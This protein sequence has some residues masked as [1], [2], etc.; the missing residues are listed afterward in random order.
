MS[1]F[2]NPQTGIS[3]LPHG[4]LTGLGQVAPLFKGEDEVAWLWLMVLGRKEEGVAQCQEPIHHMRRSNPVT[5]TLTI[6]DDT[7]STQINAQIS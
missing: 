7:G 1:S 6:G 5:V 2:E 3:V 4:C